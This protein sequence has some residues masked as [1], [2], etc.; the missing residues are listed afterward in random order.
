[1]GEVDGCHAPSTQLPLDAVSVFERFGQSIRCQ[2]H[3]EVEDST[4]S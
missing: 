4:L 2:G 3:S 1:V